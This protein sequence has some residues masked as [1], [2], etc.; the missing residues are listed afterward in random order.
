VL[1]PSN[2][3]T[4]S[5]EEVAALYGVLNPWGPSD[6]FYLEMVMGAGSV[7]DVGCGTGTLLHRARDTGHDG[8]LCG[9]DPDRAMLAVARSR[10]NIEWREGTAASMSFMDEFD[11]AVMTGHAFQ[12]LVSDVDVRAS[13]TAIRTALVPGGRFAFETRNPLVRAWEGWDSMMPIEVIDPAGR[14][15]R[16][17]WDVE[18]I[19][20]DVISLSEITTD[21]ENALLRV[22]RAGLRFMDGETV[23]DFLLDAGFEIEAQFGD[24]DRAALD[25]TSPEIITIARS[26]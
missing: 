2:C 6:A 12:Y 25:P 23:R 1:N 13:V 3:L 17:S 16:V 24:W 9:V 22:D 8:R 11:L 10:P 20:A 19:A 18:V 21:R 26:R 4:Y 5:D 7:L 15:V 14:A